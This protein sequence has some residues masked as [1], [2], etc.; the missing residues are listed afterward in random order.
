[1]VVLS[2][3]TSKENSMKT[4]ANRFVI[5]ITFITFILYGCSKTT[6]INS[7]GNLQSGTITRTGSH[8]YGLLPTTPDQILNVPLYSREAFNSSLIE[9]GV[10]PPPSVPKVYTL[11][12]PPVR[13]Q[14]QIGSCTAFCG[15]ESDEILYYYKNQSWP[16]TLSPAF[17]YYCERVLILKQRITADN[18]ASMVNIPQAL[19]K[20]G[21]CLETSYTYP[22]SNTSTA[23]KTAPTSTALTE[24]LSY[25]IGQKKT[26]Y[27]MIISGDTA[28][29]KNIL[30]SNTPV[31]LG[32][33]VYDNTKYAYFEGLNT[34][35]YTYNP[36]TSTGKLAT[37][38]RLLG[39]HAVP[40]IGYDDN[41]KAF[42]IENSWGTSWGNGG[43]FY[44]PYT[45]FMSKTIVPSSN[46]YYATLN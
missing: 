6:D 26:N 15:A 5:A 21:D 44:M 41:L 13:D 1:M 8:V 39:G 3:L 9:K 25:V 2:F 11:V 45:V 17:V 33:N 12:S 29:V 31:M 46:V 34:T 36:L 27:A 24:G 16:S 42:L 35:S 14:G 7:A 23:Y 22:S 32:F 18:G 43:Y 10:T 40:I 30:R 20:Y 28:A 19:Q 4:S 37:G 38:V